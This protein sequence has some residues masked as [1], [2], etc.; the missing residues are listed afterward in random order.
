MQMQLRGEPWHLLPDCSS[1]ALPIWKA[2]I[3]VRAQCIF[4]IKSNSHH[5]MSLQTLC[6]VLHLLSHLMPTKILEAEIFIPVV[7]MRGSR[8]E[9]ILQCC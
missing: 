9:T 4:V 2:A 5:L 7:E 1:S 8:V 6:Y 3:V